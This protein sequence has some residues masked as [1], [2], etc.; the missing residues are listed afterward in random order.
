MRIFSNCKHT[1]SELKR[2]LAEMGVEI[3]LTTY[4]D[5]IIKDDPEFYTKELLGYSYMITD[6]SDKDELPKAFRKEGE[7]DWA[8]EEFKERIGQ[9][10]L[11]PGK[12][13]K[14]R[15]V[16]EEFVHNGQFSYTYSERIGNQ[17]ER[18]IETLERDYHSR[19]AIVAIWNPEI[20]SDRTGGMARV[21]CSMF[22]QFLVRDGKVNLIYNIRSNDLFTHWC[23]DVYL[24]IKVQEYVA[25]KLDMPIGWFMQQIGSLHG[26][27]KDMKGIF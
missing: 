18:A 26:Y 6:T 23:W 25:E 12:A 2:D 27:K 10:R 22:F 19:N 1:A 4:Q 14:L 17:I 21:P 5:K 20:D 16:W 9:E 13:Y 3:H 15:K 8:E 24:A 7:M 11:N